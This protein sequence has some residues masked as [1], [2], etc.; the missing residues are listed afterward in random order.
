MINVGHNY[1]RKVSCPLCQSNQ[2]DTQKH[3][4]NCL[5]QKITNSDLYHSK[6]TKY[7][8]IFSLDLQKLISVAKLCE[9]VARKRAELLG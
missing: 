7:E 4:F 9:S 5:V 3:L 8:D 1:G 2:E 6:N